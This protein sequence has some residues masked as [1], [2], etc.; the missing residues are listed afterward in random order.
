MRI[1]RSGT[2][3][4]LLL[5]A[6]FL[7]MSVIAINPITNLNLQS[8]RA[9]GM[10]KSMKP[11]QSDVSILFIMDHD[12]GANYHFIRP[13]FEGW[14][15]TVTIAGTSDTL[16]P[17]TYQSSD[18]TVDSD[19]LISDI[20][21]V[22]EYDC[23]SIMPGSSHAL[24][25]GDTITRNLI[26]TAV[27]EGVIVAAWCRAV[28]VL[29]DADVIDGLNVTGNADYTSEY[30]AAGA[31]YLG[32]VPPVIQGNIVTGVRSR[33][34][35]LAMCEA[36]ATAVGV[37]EEDAPNVSDV[38]LASATIEPGSSTT[39]SATITDATGIESASAKIYTTNDLGQRDLSVSTIEV[40]LAVLQDDI[41]TANIT[42]LSQGRYAIDL[43]VSDTFQNSVTITNAA[44]LT[45]APSQFTL[46]SAVIILV[47]AGIGA[48]LLIAV[49]VKMR[50]P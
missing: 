2:K 45:V 39:L 46:D 37:F 9:D 24:L 44:N 41:Y 32:I 23:I 18:T 50:K 48:V 12:Y 29:A 38:S 43:L 40:D 49:V 7:M 25:L 42:N 16:T 17:C 22:T 27:E 3:I 15:W 19:I 20:D 28:R 13:I 10:G 33:F 11:A 8:E 5:I 21:D 35:R 1:T 31:T 14:G 34:Y 47:G 4:G 30:E 26:R 6:I 36:I